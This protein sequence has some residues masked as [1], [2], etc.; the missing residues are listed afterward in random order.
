MH[1]LTYIVGAGVGASLLFFPLA[2]LALSNQFKF[3]FSNAKIVMLFGVAAFLVGTL[4]L[5][6]EALIGR[7][8]LY[9]YMDIFTALILPL[10]VSGVV[11][12]V[13]YKKI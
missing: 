2:Y 1:S 10:I 3:K 13:A 11:I 12:F 6:I 8:N 4:N 9:G 5:L 7:N